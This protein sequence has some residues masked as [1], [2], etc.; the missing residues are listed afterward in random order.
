MTG[1]IQE[2][3]ELLARLP[4]VGRRSATRL[5]FHL[6]ESSPEYA[7]RL[8]TALCQFHSQI[9][10]CARCANISDR[11]PCPVCSDSHRDHSVI[12]VVEN[13]PDLWAIDAGGTYRGVYHVLHGLLAPLDGIGPDDL[14]IDLLSDRVKHDGIDEVIVA[15][16]PSVE[17]EATAMLI[18]QSLNQL[19]VRVTRIASGIPLGSELE[20]ADA[21]TLERAI[22]DRKEI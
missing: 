14:N 8:G 18:R 22:K 6:L 16:R 7:V 10:R 5:V 9:E 19:P 4:G 11:N 3:I 1:A 13:I 12:C 15:T 2:M 20:Y 17:G 21:R